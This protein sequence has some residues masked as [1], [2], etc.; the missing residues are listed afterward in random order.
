LTILGH[1]LAAKKASGLALSEWHGSALRA[2]TLELAQP[3][4]KLPVTVAIKEVACKPLGIYSLP[5][6][7][8]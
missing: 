8:W 3:A 6:K 4:E 5:G 1:E 7:S 2:L